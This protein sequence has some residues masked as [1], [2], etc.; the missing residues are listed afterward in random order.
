MYLTRHD[1][2]MIA[3]RV[4]TA[5]KKLPALCGQQINKVQPELLI[6]DLLGL[7]MDYHFLSLNGDILGLTA[8]STITVPIYDNPDRP[9][10]YRLDGHTV[11]IDKRLLSDQANV[12]RR[13]FTQVHEACHQIYRML[14]PRRYMT[15]V[16]S[17][18][19]HYCTSRRRIKD[20]EEWRT[21]TL[22]SAILMP[23]DMIRSNMIDFGLG[24]KIHRLNKVFDPNEYSRFC[25]MAS[26]MGVSK[27]ALSIRL[28][29]LGL[30]EEN[31]LENPY[32]LIDIYP[33]DVEDQNV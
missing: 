19:I 24:D 18:Q 9:E 29:Q 33:D 1:I 8:C 31:Y 15:T 17:R 14:Y 3:C 27:Q 5:Y 28:Q 4:I 26:Y 7:T 21:D 10:Y 13:H 30:L 32:N 2:E 22:T 12:G 23:Y 11:L 16:A 20:W 6:R 25:E